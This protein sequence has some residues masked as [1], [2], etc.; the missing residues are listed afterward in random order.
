MPSEVLSY[1]AYA[2]AGVATAL[3]GLRMFWRTL[4][5]YKVRKAGPRPLFGVRHRLWRDPGRVEALDMVAGPGGP[6]FTPRAPYRFIEEHSA[7]SQPCV[8]VRDAA[9]RRWRVKWGPEVPCE[10]FER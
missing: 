10:T 8:S 3:V 7:G 6:A 5:Y 4:G 1:I 2:A 9:G